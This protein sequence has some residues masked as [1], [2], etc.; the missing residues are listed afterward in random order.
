MAH[1]VAALVRVEVADR[2]V[3]HAVEHLLAQLLERALRDDGHRAVPEERGEHAYGVDAGKRRGQA[4]NLRT[5]CLPVAGLPRGADDLEGALQEGGA[6]GVDDGANDNAQRHQ[7]QEHGVE[8]EER[9]DEAGERAGLTVFG[10][11]G[12]CLTHVPRLL[13]V[14]CHPGRGL[15]PPRS[16]CFVR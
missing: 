5:C 3:L 11:L 6:D 7:G 10:A 15:V 13:P 14:L 8:R 1:D 9:F 16:S 12:G 4:Q 2:Q